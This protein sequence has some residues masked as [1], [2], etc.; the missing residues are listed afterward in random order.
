MNARQL[1]PVVLIGSA[2]YDVGMLDYRRGYVSDGVFF[3]TMVNDRRA[4][5][6]VY[7]RAEPY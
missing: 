5:V 6:F 1:L 3:F 4:R 7:P 2:C